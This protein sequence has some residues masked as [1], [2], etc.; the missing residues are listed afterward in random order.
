MC[1]YRVNDTDDLQ[2]NAIQSRS[3]SGSNI[4]VI[5]ISIFF[6]CSDYTLNI[7]LYIFTFIRIII[8]R[9]VRSRCFAARRRV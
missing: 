5:Y 2:R 9:A 1:I 6:S 7:L 8:M 4:I 3:N